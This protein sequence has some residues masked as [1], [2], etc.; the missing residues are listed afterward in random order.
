VHVTLPLPGFEGLMSTLYLQK[1][2]ILA[3][4]ILVELP[5]I[6]SMNESGI[7]TP[8]KLFDSGYVN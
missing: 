1:S 2:R 7:K 3:F 4:S 8:E 5:L 6:G